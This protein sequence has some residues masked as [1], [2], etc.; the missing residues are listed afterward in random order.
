MLLFVFLNA[1]LLLTR[2]LRAADEGAE[3]T[4]DTPTNGATVHGTNVKVRVSLG[5]DV[6]SA[7]LSVDG[8]VDL[9]ST[10]TLEWNS[11]IAA[12]GKHTLTVRG[13]QAGGTSPIGQASVSVDVQNSTHS[14]AA[15]PLGFFATLPP[16]A[17]L[18]TGKQCAAMIAATPE[19]VPANV[20]FNNTIP[21][22]AQLSKYAANG[23]AFTYQDDYTQY[24]RVTGNYIGSTDMIMR[25]AACKYGI[26]EDVVRAQAWVESGWHQGG[27]GD[28]HIR[29]SRCVQ[30][31][32]LEIMEYH[33]RYARR[34][35]GIV[36]EMLLPIVVGM[37]DQGFLRVDDLAGNHAIDRLCGGLS[38][39][40]PA[41]M[42]EWRIRQLLCERDTAAE[43]L[44]CGCGQLYSQS[45]HAKY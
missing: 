7:R 15:Q 44:R 38:L 1:G 43:H 11:T 45:E 20:P 5:P 18:P 9:P 30:G 3:I 4:I 37:A 27:V 26:S 34:R 42:Y 14:T 10:G 32:I 29:R 25:W 17:T 2:V 40:G 23:Y 13:F 31:G 41:L 35:G 28:L 22:A 8:G 39:C 21:T 6:S 12:N 33:D 24:A 36:P 19:T 16:S